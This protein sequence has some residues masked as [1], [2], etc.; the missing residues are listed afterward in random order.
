MKTTY[1]PEVDVLYLE[2]QA[3]EPGKVETRQLTD[4]IIAD[5][6]LNGMLAGLEVLDAHRVLLQ[7]A[8]SIVFEIEP[9]LTSATG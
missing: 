8:G 9:A 1:D 6:D 7:T 5:Y 2:F 4:E 3:I